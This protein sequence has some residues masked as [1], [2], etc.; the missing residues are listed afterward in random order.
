MRLNGSDNLREV[1]FDGV[2]RDD[3]ALHGIVTDHVDQLL[4]QPFQQ[5][6]AVLVSVQTVSGKML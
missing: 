4:A 5:A 6:L 3:D 1:V 2:L